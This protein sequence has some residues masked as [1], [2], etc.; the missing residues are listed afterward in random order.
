MLGVQDLVRLL[1]ASAA[2]VAVAAPAAVLAQPAGGAPVR[3]FNVSKRTAEDKA[4]PNPFLRNEA[5]Y[6]MPKGRLLGAVSGI[7]ID[8]DGKS[9]WIIERCA[10]RDMCLDS[11]ISPIIHFSPE[12]K[13]LATFG[14][15]LVAYPHGLHV[16]KDNNIWVTDLQ[17]NVDPAGR[18]GSPIGA[19]KDKVPQAGAT[20]LK[21][22]PQGKLLMTLG[23]P[24]V[25]GKDATHLSQPSDVITNANG[26]IFVADAHDSRPSNDRIVKFD[27]TGKYIKEWAACRPEDASQLDC[28]HALA[29]D[30]KGRLFVG[31][32]GNNSVDIYDQ[33][34]KL[35][36][37]WKQFG[38]PS[39][40]FI[41]K[42]DTLY[43][44]DSQSGMMEQNAFV[45]GVH[46]GSAV[47]GKVTAFI[48]DP[49]GNSSPWSGPGTMSPEGVAVAADGTIYTS[50]VMPAGL[51][52]YTPNTN[53]RFSGR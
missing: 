23:T 1:L 33:D 24:G 44:S 7:D 38:K 46:I 48:P 36:D 34:G 49:L 16:D 41:D 12:G 26:D 35:F 20:V 11:H 32:R 17:S 6:Q 21:F 3:D 39:G 30:S 22:S 13:V 37:R 27:K 51:N 19:M 42:N 2:V 8:K 50:Q 10:G 29:F 5:W 15:D 25:Y 18:R 28:G 40:L 45:K 9:I 52:K 43:V 14:A 31:N 47:T 4:L 53:T